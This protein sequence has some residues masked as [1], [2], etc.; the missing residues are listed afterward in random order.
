MSTHIDIR[1]S[2]TTKIFNV[3][4]ARSIFSLY[5]NSVSSY[6]NHEHQ[7]TH[8]GSFEVSSPWSVPRDCFSPSHWVSFVMRVSVP[9]KP[10]HRPRVVPGKIPSFP[11]FPTGIHGNPRVHIYIL[12]MDIYGIYIY[13]LYI[14]ISIWYMNPYENGLMIMNDHPKKKNG[15]HFWPICFP[16]I[17]RS[18]TPG[19]EAACCK[20]DDCRTT[21][22]NTGSKD[23]FAL[24]LVEICRDVEISWSHFNPINKSKCCITGIKNSAW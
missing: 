16:E 8:R 18:C 7:E 6:H 11:S 14:S 5:R 21:P 10:Q 13:I 1:E 17:R 2:S 12:Y 22:C 4:I 23:P 9:T 3:S 15:N 20:A 24:W 19:L